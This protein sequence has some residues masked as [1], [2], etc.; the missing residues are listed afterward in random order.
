MKQADV[1]TNTQAAFLSLADL[2]N[3]ISTQKR[4]HLATLPGDHTTHAVGVCIAKVLG[5]EPQRRLTSQSASL[6]QHASQR[7]GFGFR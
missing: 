5:I 3:V 1:D 6:S 4:P 7:R 2:K